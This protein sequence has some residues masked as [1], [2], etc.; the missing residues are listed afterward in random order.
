[1]IRSRIAL[2]GTPLTVPTGGIRRYVEELHHALQRCFPNEEFSLVSDQLHPQQGWDRRWW[3]IG[4]PKLLRRERFR[5]FHGADFS[6]P[7]LPVAPSV[8]TVHDLSPWRFPQWQ[9]DAG[10]IR[11]R[12]PLLLTL[13]LATMVITPSEAVRREVCDRFRLPATRVVATPLAA[14]SRF[15]P[16][17]PTVRER[18]YFLFVGTVEPRKNVPLLLDA[19]RQ[20]AKTQDVDLVIAGREREDAPDLEGTVRMGAVPDEALP[21]LYSGAVAVLYPSLYEGFGLPALEAMACGAAVITSDDPAIQEVTGDAA[22]R[23]DPRNGEAWVEAMDAVLA[24]PE[25]RAGLQERSLRQAAQF[26]WERTARQTHAVYE[27]AI[28]RFGR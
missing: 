19:W 15:R 13:G 2:D 27:E 26:S 23:L 3:L 18:P 12:T 11:K 20:I 22:L 8:M 4:L 17:E 9:P 7:Y 10:R 6:V 5:L 16:A 21:G 25:L 14:D 28:A 24:K 1:M